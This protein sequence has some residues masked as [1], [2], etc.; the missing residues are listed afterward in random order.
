MDNN[1]SIELLCD[2]FGKI[3]K[4][5]N[6]FIFD[7]FNKDEM[8]RI[9]NLIHP[10]SVYN[11]IKKFN[12]FI[13]SKNANFK[14]N[15]TLLYINKQI[16]SCNI[17]LDKIKEKI[18]IRMINLTV[19]NQKIKKNISD[20]FLITRFKFVLGSIMPFIFAVLWSLFQ[21]NN[22]SYKF[23]F[24]I[25]IGLIFCHISANTFNDYFDWISN[26]DISNKNYIILSSGGSR[27]IE[28]DMISASNMLKISIL[29]ISIAFFI[30][31]YIS[32]YISYKIILISIIAF[33][34]IFFYS[35][36]PFHFASK[37]GIGEVSHIFCL[38]PMI[39]YGTILTLTQ[40]ASIIDFIIGLPF[41]LLITCC[42]LTNEYPDS[43]Y[44][45]IFNKKNLAVIAGEKYL[46]IIFFTLSTL[47][48]F[49]FFLLIKYQKAPNTFIILLIM[50]PYFIK[51]NKI[52]FT[53]KT[54]NKLIL[55]SCIAS[56]K[57]YLYTSL[58]LLISIIINII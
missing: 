20:L 12:N 23:L 24:I 25:L 45:K 22:I 48:F 37:F 52:V 55:E 41:G 50:I 16:L 29:F 51:A 1:F 7:F 35:A 15:G 5:N 42:L 13:E 53:L 40:K 8:N 27:A 14:D 17:I 31:L 58:L 36:P 6:M 32:F 19:Y 21:Y 54:K 47:A 56:F 30:S 2:E 44:D 4:I 18:Y 3:L 46:P 34:F 57:L 26:R 10:N 38:G 28:F 49:V 9:F 11:F 39:T 43:K 33:I